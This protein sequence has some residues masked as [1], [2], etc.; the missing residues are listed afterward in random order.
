[1]TKERETMFQS[2]FEMDTKNL[3]QHRNEIKEQSDTAA[4]PPKYLE[5]LSTSKIFGSVG[6][7]NYTLFN[8]LRILLRVFSKDL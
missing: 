8:L 6:I 1:M 7:E 4:S 3:F 5:I 2:Y